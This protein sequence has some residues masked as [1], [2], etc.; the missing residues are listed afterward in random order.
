[1]TYTLRRLVV[2][3]ISNYNILPG[4]FQPDPMPAEMITWSSSM[5]DAPILDPE[6]KAVVVG[7]DHHLSYVKICKAASYLQNPDCIFGM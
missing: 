6:V 2:G 5:V 1:M 3:I 4:K 7:F